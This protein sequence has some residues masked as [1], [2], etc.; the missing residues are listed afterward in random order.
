MPV[1]FLRMEPLFSW[2][3]QMGLSTAISGNEPGDRGKDI[4]VD[5]GRSASF[6]DVAWHPNGETALI[7]GDLG[8][9]LTIRPL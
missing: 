6:N 9:A 1:M 2:W 3:V 4:S 5:S 7:A 8:A